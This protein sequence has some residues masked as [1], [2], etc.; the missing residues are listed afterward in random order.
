MPISHGMERTTPL[1][2]LP[3]TIGSQRPRRG[4][5]HGRWGRATV[6]LFSWHVLCWIL[7][8]DGCVFSSIIR[9]Y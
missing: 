6:R 4:N 5:I 7:N 1:I 8:C 3:P 2:P 9:C